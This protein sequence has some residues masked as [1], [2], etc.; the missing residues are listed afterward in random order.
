MATNGYATNETSVTGRVVSVNDKGLKLDGHESWFN[1]SKFAVGVVLPQRGDSVIVTLD[2]QGFIRS[3]VTDGS[4]QAPSTNGTVASSAPSS[5]DRTI[6]RLAILK[7]AAEFAAPRS[8]LLSDD[9]ISIARSWERWVNEAPLDDR[10]LEV[11]F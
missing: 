5:R 1:V 6:S 8:E 9:V 4:A 2:R 7:A 11:A 10:E 3:C